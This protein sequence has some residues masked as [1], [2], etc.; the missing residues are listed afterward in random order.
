MKFVFVLA[1][2]SKTTASRG[3]F[4]PETTAHTYK[5][6]SG[7]KHLTAQPGVN[8]CR[9]LWLSE[10]VDQLVKYTHDAAVSSS[11]LETVWKLVLF[12]LGMPAWV[13]I[14]ALCSLK[15]TPLGHQYYC[16]CRRH[17]AFYQPMPL[18]WCD[19]TLAKGAFGL[20]KC[21]KHYNLN[22]NDREVKSLL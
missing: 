6:Q 22:L 2:I 4:V 17:L 3:F 9:A 14:A 12:I 15:P 21:S 8:C 19:P 5:P 16:C 20:F 13:F 10:L 7:I 1:V 18:I 11:M